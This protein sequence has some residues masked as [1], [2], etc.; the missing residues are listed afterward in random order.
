MTPIAPPMQSGAS[1]GRQEREAK[2]MEVIRNPG[3]SGA[4]AG[5]ERRGPADQKGGS[6]HG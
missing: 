5:V 6:H 4:A 3:G 1:G 2:A